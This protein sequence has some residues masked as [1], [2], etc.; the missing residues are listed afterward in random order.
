M[1]SYGNEEKKPHFLLKIKNAGSPAT[2]ENCI[3]R[4]C[5][6]LP[7]RELSDIHQPCLP[8]ANSAVVQVS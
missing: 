5:G 1:H 6:V 4:N 8:A 7:S 2:V 3:L